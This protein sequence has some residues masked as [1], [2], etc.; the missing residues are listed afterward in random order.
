[1]I[2][3]CA[4]PPQVTTYL[5]PEGIL[6]G[7]STA[8]LHDAKVSSKR[9]QEDTIYD[10]HLDIRQKVARGNCF[11][12]VLTGPHAGLLKCLVSVRHEAGPNC[13]VLTGN[14]H[15][16]NSSQI[17]MFEIVKCRFFHPTLGH[18]FRLLWHVNFVH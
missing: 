11:L 8:V 3:F 6:P 17:E 4:S 12:E 15:N 16:S 14:T 7:G 13:M 10:N 2:G 9:G 5:I 1:M 18:N